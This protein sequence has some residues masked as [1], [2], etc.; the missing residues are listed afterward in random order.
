MDAGYVFNDGEWY[1]ESAQ[2]ALKYAISIGYESLD[3]AY[4]DESYYYTEWDVEDESYWYECHDGT[5]YEVDES[6]RVP[7]DVNDEQVN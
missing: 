1:T 6:G 4:E 2:D 3:D 5:W 7:V